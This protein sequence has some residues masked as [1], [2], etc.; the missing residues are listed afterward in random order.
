MQIAIEMMLNE[1][2]NAYEGEVVQGISSFSH[3]QNLAND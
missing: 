1:I 3:S 2:F